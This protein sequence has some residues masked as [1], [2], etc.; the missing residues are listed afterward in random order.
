MTI[1]T[2]IVYTIKT[3][4]EHTGLS[5]GYLKNK[6]SSLKKFIAEFPQL[7]PNNTGLNDEGL[8]IYDEYL[9]LCSN[10]DPR[11]NRRQPEMTFEQFKEYAMTEYGIGD[12][13]NNGSEVYEGMPIEEV[14]NLEDDNQELAGGLSTVESTSI[15][16]VEVMPISPIDSVLD[17]I[18]AGF[19]QM[20]EALSA[21]V[22]NSMRKNVTNKIVEEFNLETARLQSIINQ[23]NN[24]QEGN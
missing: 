18:D 23:I 3:I 4:A 22:R 16:E 8:I 14:I 20:G 17:G 6:G 10:L 13:N 2:E 12:A 7:S 9:Y 24:N 15:V 11:G 1:E 5:E 21:K 19:Q